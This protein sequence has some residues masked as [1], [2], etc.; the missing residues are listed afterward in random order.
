MRPPVL[1]LAIASATL[2]A[3]WETTAWLLHEDLS[4]AGAAESVAPSRRASDMS[5]VP[6]VDV[7]TPGTRP[8]AR[9]TP[10]PAFGAGAAGNVPSAGARSASTDAPAAPAVSPPA[11]SPQIEPQAVGEESAGN[12]HR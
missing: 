2:A 9:P 11:T 12:S 5:P 8:D 10:V 1:I 3:L 4:S 6:Q 7:P